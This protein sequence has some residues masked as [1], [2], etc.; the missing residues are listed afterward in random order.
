M[1]AHILAPIDFS[2][3]TDKVIGEAARLARAFEAKLCLVH[4]ATPS[5]GVTTFEAEMGVSHPR[6][7]AAAGLRHDHRRLQ[8]CEIACRAEGLDV[9]SMLV[10]G[11][12]GPKIIEEAER[13]KP[14]MVVLGSHGHGALHHLLM[15][16]VCEYVMKH[17]TCPVMIVPSRT[18][19]Y[20]SH[21]EAAATEAAV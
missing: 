11:T 6:E 5:F 17:G 13:M 12:P 4:I 7:E 16:S 3:V 8:E 20:S 19:T 18:G 2:D 10:N 9:T 15:G 1:K 14:L 21:A